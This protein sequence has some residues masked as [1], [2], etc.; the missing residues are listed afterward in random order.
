VGRNGRFVFFGVK[1]LKGGW[2][3]EAMKSSLC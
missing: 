3:D 2:E 1:S